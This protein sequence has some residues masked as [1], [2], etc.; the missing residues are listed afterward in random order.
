MY[1]KIDES[2]P[3]RQKESL[4]HVIKKSNFPHE[5]VLVHKQ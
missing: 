3:E 2:V 5:K 1:L 4:S